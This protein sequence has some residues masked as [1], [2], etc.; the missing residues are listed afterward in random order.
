[1]VD[2][3]YTTASAFD[4]RCKSLMCNS[5]NMGTKNLPDMIYIPKPQGCRPESWGHTYQE[6]HERRSALYKKFILRCTSAWPYSNFHYASNLNFNR[7]LFVNNLSYN[8][9]RI[10]RKHLTIKFNYKMIKFILQILTNFK[11]TIDRYVY[12]KNS[13][14][15]LFGSKVFPGYN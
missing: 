10:Q 1:M 7:F 9:I 11:H 13:I 3:L 14:S 2:H 5:C 15:F 6:N 12:V 4:L 8:N